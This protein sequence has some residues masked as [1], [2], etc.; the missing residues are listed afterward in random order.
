MHMHS[1]PSNAYSSMQIL[2]MHRMHVASI[3]ASI[4]LP[5]ALTNIPPEKINDSKI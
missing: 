2:L 4:F 3:L 1:Y 5:L